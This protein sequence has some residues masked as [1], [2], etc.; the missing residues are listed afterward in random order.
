MIA[1]ANSMVDEAKAMNAN[2]RDNNN[3]MHQSDVSKGV[4]NHVAAAT[5]LSIAPLSAV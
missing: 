1:A 4:V 3:V 2:L 5:G